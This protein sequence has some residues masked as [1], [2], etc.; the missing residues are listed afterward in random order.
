MIRSM[1]AHVPGALRALL[2]EIVD[3]AGLFPPAGL[4]MAEAVERYAAYQSDPDRWML[5]RFVV[6]ASRLDAFATA[7]ALYRRDEAPWRLSV[8]LGAEAASDLARVADVNRG[9]LGPGLVADAVEA[10]AAT[11]AEIERLADARPPGLAAFVELPL[12]EDPAP[13]VAALAARGLHAKLRTG[14]VTPELFPSAAH[15]ARALAAC[16]RA[17]VAL[18]LTAGLHHPLR[19]EYPLTY[20][21]GSAC[22]TMFGYLNA[23]LAAILLR[24]GLPEADAVRLLEER[25]RGAFDFGDDAV[26]WRDHAVATPR[27]A[28]ARARFAIAFGSC[29]FRE[30]VD[31]LHDLLA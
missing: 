15:V 5:G 23:F 10:K 8:L 11:T 18:K 3:Y 22:G 21:Q 6:P 17:G 4:G 2:A 16:A 30:P 29:S 13:L 27:L 24:E 1:S 14:G 9:A 12:A 25:D 31:E 20:A 7:A 26:R 28:D 19:A